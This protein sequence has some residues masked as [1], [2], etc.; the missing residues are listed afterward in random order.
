MV[1]GAL[2]GI[3]FSAIGQTRSKRDDEMDV[4]K[5]QFKFRGGYVEAF[6]EGVY[7]AWKEFNLSDVE[8]APAIVKEVGH[9]SLTYFERK[10][11]GNDIPPT[12]RGS[13]MLFNSEV[14]RQS[15][16]SRAL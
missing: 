14:S 1:S 16:I 12:R 13:E 4:S 3:D 15:R 8:N 2:T 11:S 9:G 10:E 5:I 6:K 7:N